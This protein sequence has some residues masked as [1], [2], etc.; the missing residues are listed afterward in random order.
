MEKGGEEK[1]GAEYEE[2]NVKRARLKST[3]AAL[4]EDPLLGDV[5]RNPSLADVDTLLH[6]ELG[7]A[8]RISILKLD[9]TSFREY[10]QLSNC[11]CSS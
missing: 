7:S 8:M 1:A 6:L 10:S 3:L 11:C 2:S 4:L 5:P 9:T